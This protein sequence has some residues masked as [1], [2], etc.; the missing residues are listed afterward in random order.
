MGRPAEGMCEYHDLMVDGRPVGLTTDSCARTSIGSSAASSVGCAAPAVRAAPL[1]FTHCGRPFQPHVSDRRRRGPAPRPAS[2]TARAASTQEHTT[3][4]REARILHA[5][6]ADG[7]ART[8]RRGLRGRRDRHRCAVLRYGIGSTAPS[9]IARSCW[10]SVCPT[11]TSRRRLALRSG[12]CARRSA[13]VDVIAIELGDLGPHDDISRDR[14]SACDRSGKDE[15]TRAAD[16]RCA[17][18]GPDGR[19]LRRNGTRG[20][21]IPTIAPAM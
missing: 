18:R 9:S 16:H 11:W 1:Q 13:S 19:K 5:L 17:R 7:C 6:R 2:S 4:L 14:S 8:A 3:L 20:S 12:G 21:C 15:D 10:R